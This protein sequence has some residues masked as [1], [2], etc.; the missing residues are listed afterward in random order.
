M[1]SVSEVFAS[2]MAL[3]DE[4]SPDG[5]ISSGGTGEYAHRTPSCIN[6][7]LSELKMLLGERKSWLPVE[8]MDESIPDVE[9]SYA[10]CALPYGL[11][12][13]LLVDENPAAASFYQQRYEALRNIF[14][15]KQAAAFE[16]ITDLYGGIGIDGFGRW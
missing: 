1:A 16:N 12:A 6:I 10:L 3:M 7:M 4:L 14:L 15:S 8:G 5:Q 13:N 9:N 11:A 2:A